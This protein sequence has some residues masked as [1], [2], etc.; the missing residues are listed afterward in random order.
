LNFSRLRIDPEARLVW[1]DDEQVDLTAI[2]FDLL[3]TLAEHRGRVLS[4]EQLLEQ[5]W[6]HDFYGEERVVD[7]HLGHVRKKIE[8]NPS[9][10]E[11]II[12]VRSVGYR[13]AGDAE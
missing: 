2:E 10:P 7:V 4:R 1:K 11:F 8:N 12:T 6:G 9:Q 13:F 5:V 3:H